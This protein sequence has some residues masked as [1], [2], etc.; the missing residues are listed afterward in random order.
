[1]P[2][3]PISD[4]ELRRALDAQRQFHGSVR[5]AAEH[6]GINYYTLRSRL[7]IAR[8]RG[9]HLSNGARHV[10]DRA[11][12]GYRE[13]KGGWIHDYDESGKKIGTTRWAAEEEALSED[14]LLRIRSAFEGM[15]PLKRVAAP[16]DF[17][18]DTCNVIP[19]YDVHWGMAAWREET[20][21]ED[22]DFALARDDVMRGLE[23][24][25]SRAPRAKRGILL[26]GGDLLHADDNSAKTPGHK[27]PLDVA[28][29]MYQATDTLIEVLK[30][31]V[32]RALEHHDEIV[33][34]VLRGNHDE[35]SHR[36]VA[37]ALREWLRDQPN[38]TI[39]M[40]YR[41]VFMH[42]WGR[43]A[44]FGHHGDKQAPKDFTLKL[45]DICPFWSDCPHRYAYTGHKHTM[46]A[47]RIGGMNW[48]RIEPFAPADVYGAAWTNRR[49]IK[50]DSYDLK[51]GRV[52]TAL[53]PL[54]RD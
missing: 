7:R 32:I 21:H 23:A 42:Q 10:V 44:L 33:V 11:Q 45:A 25:L 38:A 6:L 51:R 17:A 3:P 35:N 2:T 20:G 9:L 53:D 29:R 12:L 41:D 40:N 47:Q 34:R 14:A 24:V 50:I 16:Q 19:W 52:N 13:A 49:G 39:D 26:L 54:E 28:G 46:E 8:D 27:H 15:A 36:A 37:F 43:T 18:A 5:Q 22:Y 48:E 4:D 30:Y 31:S 1:M